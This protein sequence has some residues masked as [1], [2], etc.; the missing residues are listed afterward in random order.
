MN[1]MQ[2]IT[3]PKQFDRMVKINGKWVLVFLTVLV[4]LVAGLV[5]FV[6]TQTIERKIDKYGLVFTASSAELYPELSLDTGMMDTN[7]LD[8]TIMADNLYPAPENRVIFLMVSDK[9]LQSGVFNMGTKVRV[10]SAKGVVIAID[11]ATPMSY[12]EV[13]ERFPLE[14]DTLTMMGVYPGQTYY[15]VLVGEESLIETD[16]IKAME[17]EVPAERTDGQ[18][19]RSKS[20][21]W[22]DD[23][24][25][26]LP[27]DDILYLAP[28]EI[29][30]QSI[31][32]SSFILK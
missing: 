15:I 24:E 26:Y 10:G 21:S 18:A 4:A 8:L 9:E 6:F 19:V 30:I 23:V 14:D 11:L 17:T 16:P 20:E 5:A 28:C 32:L 25:L 2:R 3:T 31:K 22:L 13:V 7:L 1:Q 12:S 29:I 27:E